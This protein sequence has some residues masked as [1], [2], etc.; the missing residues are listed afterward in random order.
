[1]P[2]SA[3]PTTT[4]NT[5]PRP[6][7]RLMPPSTTTRMTSKIV[8]PCMIAICML[9]VVADPDQPGEPGEE[10]HNHIF[11]D[12]QRAQ[13]DAGHPGGLGIVALA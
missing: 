7:I 8:V 1:M 12:D 4:L 5:P 10:S 11:Q 2:I 3:Q 6:P 13:R 9:P